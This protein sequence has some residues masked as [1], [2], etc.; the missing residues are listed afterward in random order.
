MKK[1]EY[2]KRAEEVYNSLSD[3]KPEEI[4]VVANRLW[5]IA[6]DKKAKPVE[7]STG[8]PEHLVKKQDSA[9]VNT[10]TPEEIRNWRSI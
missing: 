10:E 8:E 9:G 3:L 1:E 2:Q 7:Q 5:R 4:S 6:K